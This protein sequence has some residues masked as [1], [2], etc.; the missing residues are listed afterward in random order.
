MLSKRSVDWYL[1]DTLR[2]PFAWI[3]VLLCLLL[4]YVLGTFL[5]WNTPKGAMTMACHMRVLYWHKELHPPEIA[6]Y[7]Q[8]T[9]A[10]EQTWIWLP[11][12]ITAIDADT[13]QVDAPV[14]VVEGSPPAYHHPVGYEARYPYR[15][16]CLA[17]YQGEAFWATEEQ[18]QVLDITAE[19]MP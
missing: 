17:H 1:Y 15:Y 12:Q 11:S 3:G 19:R 6:H 18:V 10:I 4:V 2:S 16:S 8:L 9:V 5:V 7:N 14:T 13:Y